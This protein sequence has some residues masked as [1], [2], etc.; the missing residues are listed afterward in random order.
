MGS[1]PSR[2][3]KEKEVTCGGSRWCSLV[4]VVPGGDPSSLLCV[5]SFF[6][7]LFPFFSPLRPPSSSLC[8]VL[9]LSNDGAGSAGGGPQ[10]K[11]VILLP[12]L[13][14]FIFLLRS[15]SVFKTTLLCFSTFFS[16][17]SP[18][19][20]SCFFFSNLSIFSKPSVSHSLNFSPSL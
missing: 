2:T 16:L 20:V 14:F 3:K 1:G 10:L 18:L 7:F 6:H 5:S 12:F 11:T 15:V 8:L 17:K 19:S 13:A 9:S 4:A